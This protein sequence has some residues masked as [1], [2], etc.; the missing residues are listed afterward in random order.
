MNYEHDKFMEKEAPH[1]RWQRLRDKIDELIRDFDNADNAD[2]PLL[3][4]IHLRINETIK[5]ANA[6]GVFPPVI[7]NINQTPQ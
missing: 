6:I 3:R 7:I 5:E 1:A 2:K 4:S